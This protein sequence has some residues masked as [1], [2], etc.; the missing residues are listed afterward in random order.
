MKTAGDV[1]AHKGAHVWSIKPIESVF[2]AIQIMADKE[3]GALLVM[4]DDDLVGIVSERDYARKV[5]LKDKASHQIPVSLIMTAKIIS[6][7]S[8]DT[9]DH[10]VRLMKDNHIRHLPVVDVGVVVGM[11]SLRDLFSSIIEEQASTIDQLEHY[12]RGDT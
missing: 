11:L 4:I 12:I 9:V 1:L 2:D 6:V 10:C 5:I 7:T 3:I 8:N